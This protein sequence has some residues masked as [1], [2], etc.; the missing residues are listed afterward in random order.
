MSSVGWYAV[1]IAGVALWRLVELVVSR[2]HLRWALA[3]GGRESGQGHFPAMVAL[4]TG[5]LVGALVE[6]VAADRPFCPVL[7]WSMV[8]VLVATMAL[9]LWCMAALGR[10][11]NTRVVVVP[12]APRV[13]SGPYRFLPHPNY[14]VVAV[15]GVA[16]PLVHGA[17]V[18]AVVF[19][20]L[21]AVLLLR[22]RIPAEDAAL[23]SLRAPGG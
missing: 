6:V 3:H 11:W 1:L 13:T 18:T 9:R 22:Y 20:V 14:L 5:L 10:Q 2:R 16:L 8:A 21:D 15:E 19:T 12:G 7:G 4:H 17:W 23:A